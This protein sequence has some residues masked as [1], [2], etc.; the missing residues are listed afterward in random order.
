MALRHNRE[1]IK[2]NVQMALRHNREA[3]KNNMIIIV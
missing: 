3:I 2:N 1:A